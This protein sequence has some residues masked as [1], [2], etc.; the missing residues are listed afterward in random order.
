MDFVVKLECGK[1]PN[2]E[3]DKLLKITKSFVDE[4]EEAY[5]FFKDTEIGFNHLY[6]ITPDVEKEM[7]FGKENPNKG[8]TKILHS[9]TQSQVKE[10][11]S[12]TGRNRKKAFHMLVIWV[13]TLWDSKYRKKISEALDCKAND[14]KSDMLG[15][16]RYLRNHIAHCKGIIPNKDHG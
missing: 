10:R 3:L 9:A 8:N 6:G 2:L 14:V 1:Y 5:G 7:Y 4:T 16:I 15:A 11:N 13:Y 12:L